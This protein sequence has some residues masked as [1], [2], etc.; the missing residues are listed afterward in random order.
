[1]FNCCCVYIV[2]VFILLLCLYCCCVYIPLAVA[3]Y[4]RGCKQIREL[5]VQLG[6][7]P[8]ALFILLLNT[9]QFEF[10]LKEVIII[11]IIINACVLYAVMIISF[12]LVIARVLNWNNLS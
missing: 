5:I 11:I 1:M 9:A 12:A 7:N 2:V 6:F 3:E 10:L 8:R 4:H